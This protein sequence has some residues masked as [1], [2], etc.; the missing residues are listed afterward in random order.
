MQ[1]KIYS[2]SDGTLIAERALA[3]DL[4]ISDCLANAFDAQ[5]KWQA[6]SISKRAEY[7]SAAIAWFMS[8]KIELAT[9]ISQL[10]GR[11]I[12]YAE[13][14]IAGLKERADY[15]ISIAETALADIEIKAEDRQYKRIIRPTALGT[16]FIIAPWNF[17]YLTAINSIIPALMAGNCVILKHASQTLLCAERFIQ[18]FTA[19]GL[20]AGIFQYLHLSHAQTLATI[21][22]QDIHYVS[23]TG[24]VSAGKIIEANLAGYFKP[25]ALEL[26]G[27]DAAY[28]RKD[29]DLKTTA[30]SLVEGSFFNSGQSCCGIERIYVDAALFD[31]FVAEFVV[32]TK[33]LILGHALDSKTNL[34]PMINAKAIT[35][36][37]AQIDQA[38]ELGAQVHISDDDFPLLNFTKNEQAELA[39]GHYMMPQ[40]LTQVS[41]D[42][43]IM[44][45]ES[46][47]PVIGIMSVEND[48]QAIEHIND[49][50][51][52][53]SA[54][55]WTQDEEAGLRLCDDINTGTIFINRCDYLDPS[56]PWSGIK[57]SGR[58][59]SLSYLGYQQLTRPKS[60]HIKRQA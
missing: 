10:M 48:T 3:N 2:P 24:S 37:Q 12:Q 59:C 4:D 1:H 34:G 54:S 46:F 22:E 31:D 27:K 55:I 30:E 8:N 33:Q 23:F 18:A 20:P 41:H 5:K 45:E 29:A 19:A 57:D 13:G 39:Q 9:E 35:H 58:G 43:E 52:G 40:V 38:I 32:Q 17:P 36:A 51:Y 50:A 47:A 7:C 14:E 60:I 25:L 16:A 56:L 44:R 49:S 11:P 28:V 53:L 42:M 21:R 26:G 6:T 15:M